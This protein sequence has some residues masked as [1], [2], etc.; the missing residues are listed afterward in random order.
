[1][2]KLKSI[3][4]AFSS[5][6]P[7][8]KESKAHK[9]WKWLADNGSKTREEIY[10]FDK[11]Y[12]TVLAK[13]FRNGLVKQDNDGKY[14]AVPDYKFEDIKP[15]ENQNDLERIFQNYK[16]VKY[17]DMEN[18][19]KEFNE[20]LVKFTKYENLCDLFKT[21]LKA[22]KPKIVGCVR[23]A[24]TIDRGNSPKVYNMRGVRNKVH[25]SKYFADS[26]RSTIEN[27]DDAMEYPS[28]SIGNL[29]SMIYVFGTSLPGKLNDIIEKTKN[30]LNF[31]KSEPNAPDP[32]YNV[33]VR[34][35]LIRT[36]EKL[37]S[38]SLL[39]C[40]L[41]KPLIGVYDKISNNDPGAMPPRPSDKITEIPNELLNDYKKLAQ[42]SE[43]NTKIHNLIFG[44]LMSKAK[45]L[46]PKG[47]DYSF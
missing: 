43:Y 40:E 33:R 36:Y 27:V 28:N 8:G 42:N 26:F 20:Y 44:E 41:V 17:Q 23:I 16:S 35:E 15:I 31:Y 37:K 47:F 45:E 13:Y 14:S 46:C 38:N 9:L 21:K 7:Q 22:I 34:E 30:S 24:N 1:M 32:E 25:P 2:L 29:R 39:L 11:S 19:V 10:H 12:S 4:E 5:I 6:D 18:A 3:K